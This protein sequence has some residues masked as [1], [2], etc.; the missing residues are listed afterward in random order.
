M[1]WILGVLCLVLITLSGVSIYFTHQLHQAKINLENGP[2][3]LPHATPGYGWCLRCGFSWDKVE[4]RTVEMTESRGTF[5]LCEG[6]WIATTV[7]ARNHY[8]LW[9]WGR[10]TGSMLDQYGKVSS[11]GFP[12]ETVIEAVRN[13]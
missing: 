4:P 6:C 11:P 3:S 1:I 10:N 5:V 12:P 13:A 7:N 9:G 8:H 2:G